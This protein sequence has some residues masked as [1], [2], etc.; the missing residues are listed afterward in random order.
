[1]N[2]LKAWN[3]NTIHGNTLLSGTKLKIYSESPS[4]GD[5]K[6]SSRNSRSSRGRS[7]PTAHSVK[8]GETLEAIAK[9]HG[10]SVSEIKKLNPKL[11]E[12]Q[13]QIGAK[14]KVKK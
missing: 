5:A 13:M 11:K 9:R 6:K 3:E 7:K 10:M 14:V 4:K 2:D 1:M 8:K 12:T